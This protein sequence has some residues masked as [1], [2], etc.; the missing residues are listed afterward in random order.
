MSWQI[1][2]IKE[3]SWAPCLFESPAPQ[4]YQTTM[5]QHFSYDALS[6]VVRLL[7]NT[8]LLIEGSLN[9]TLSIDQC[10]QAS[11]RGTSGG[12]KH[13]NN[14]KKKL[15][16]TASPQEW[17]T[18]H[19]HGNTYFQRHDSFVY[20]SNKTLVSVLAP[21]R[22]YRTLSSGWQKSSQVSINENSFG[23]A[24]EVY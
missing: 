12:P 18:T 7:D 21:P 1:G 8:A 20:T 3:D 13:R 2:I 11:R 6:E 5:T 10:Q 23:L 19:R 14:A 17:S 15:T 16:N 4:T 24:A 9:H 22:V